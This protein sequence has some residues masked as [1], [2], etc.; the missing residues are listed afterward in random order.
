MAAWSVADSRGKS[1]QIGAAVPVIRTLENEDIQA[2]DSA[3][4]KCFGCLTLESRWLAAWYTSA[5]TKYSVKRLQCPG[6]HDQVVPERG[7]S[8]NIRL[9]FDRR[10]SLLG[11]RW[12]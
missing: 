3:T 5:V 1:D 10:L 8:A 9:F 11:W 7:G 4:L 6:Q 12:R 2:V